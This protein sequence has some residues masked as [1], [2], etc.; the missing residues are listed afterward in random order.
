MKD[1]LECS[2]QENQISLTLSQKQQ[3]LQFL[4][5]LQKWNQIFNLTAIHSAK[6]MVY[7]HLIDSLII[8][9]TLKGQR[10]LDVGTGGGFPGIPLAIVNPQQHWTLLDKN[11]KKT[12]FLT[13]VVAECELKNVEIAQARCEDFQAPQCF[14]SILSRAF[15]TLKLFANSTAHLLCKN[16][17]LL[18]MK[19][20]VP[21]EEIQELPKHFTVTAIHRLMIKGMPIERHI[22]QL[23][24][25][26]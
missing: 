22:I 15:G 11:S 2:L 12:R 14:D 23:Q 9:P 20:K 26:G 1:L 25:E 6:E 13:Q 24:K 10:F 21:D 19:G 18:A 8:Q 17:Q 7:L 4:D 16:G 3:L 5:L